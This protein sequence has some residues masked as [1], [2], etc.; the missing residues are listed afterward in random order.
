MAVS[1]NDGVRKLL[2]AAGVSVLTVVL[3]AVGVDTGAAIYAEYQLSRNVRSAAS[4]A[5]DPW[6]A[7]LGFPFIPQA[8][9]HRYGELSI[10]LSQ[11]KSLLRRPCTTSVWR[12]PPG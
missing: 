10:T 1:Q 5:F 9:G 6:V 11:E 3:V 8:V 4:L 2:S 7:I 12:R